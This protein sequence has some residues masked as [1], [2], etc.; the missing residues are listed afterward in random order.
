MIEILPSPRQGL[1]VLPQPQTW[2]ASLIYLGLCSPCS[3]LPMPGL[4]P[5][6]ALASISD[7]SFLLMPPNSGVPAIITCQSSHV[8]HLP[9]SSSSLYYFFLFQCMKW[10]VVQTYCTQGSPGN[11][12]SS[13]MLKYRLCMGRQLMILKQHAG[14][15]PFQ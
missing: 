5:V 14:N 12:I 1:P 10:L 7:F 9:F 2:R 8:P 13:G 15:L 3:C 11:R 4:K 6:S